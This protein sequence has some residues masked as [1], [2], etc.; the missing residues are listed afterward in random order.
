MKI[1]I[2]GFN[3]IIKG[4]LVLDNINLTLESGQIYGLFGENGSGKTMLLRAICGLLKPTS[5]IIEID[6]R[7][8]GKDMDFPESIGAIIEN[9]EFF[10]D[11]TGYQ[12]LKRLANIKKIIGDT[13]IHNVL[14]KVGLDPND[15]RSV[16]KYSLG[17]KKRLSIAQAIMESPQILLLDEPTNALDEAGIQMFQ[18]IMNEEKEKGTLIIIASHN[19]EDIL[20]LVEHKIYLNYGA[21][22][23][24]RN[25]L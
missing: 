2:E 15:R 11:F 4:Y 10:D 17:M 14:T 25:K 23:P 5:G 8:L 20:D 21:I 19:K 6:N 12:N 9:P 16:R 24:E 1:K 18:N 22:C 13:E 3:K 7:T